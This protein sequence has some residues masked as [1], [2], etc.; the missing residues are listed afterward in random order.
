MY[1][2]FL[3]VFAADRRQLSLGY[4]WVNVTN[5]R[6]TGASVARKAHRSTNV[7]AARNVCLSESPSLPAMSVCPGPPLPHL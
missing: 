5:T 1:V 3:F 6:D 4:L 7:L 2:S